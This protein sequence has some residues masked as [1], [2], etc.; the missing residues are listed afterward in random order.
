MVLFVNLFLSAFFLWD[1]YI[2]HL[3]QIF[4][5]RDGQLRNIGI[6][7]IGSLKIFMADHMVYVIS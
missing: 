7:V 1:A 5:Q 6:V 4:S 2:W 3:Y